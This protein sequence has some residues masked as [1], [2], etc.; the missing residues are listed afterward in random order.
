MS[1]Y[2]RRAYPAVLSRKIKEAILAVEINRQYSKQQILE[3]YLNQIYYGNLAYGI[4]A[5]A[6]TYFGK[7]AQDP[8]LAEASMLAGLPQS[9]AIRPYTNPEGAKNRQTVRAAADGR[10]Q[11]YLPEEA[12]PPCPPTYS[13]SLRALPSSPPFC[14]LRAPRTGKDCPA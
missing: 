7:S 11:L 3:I 13:S 9:P 12:N 4:E 5:A 2:S 14:Q 6:Q 10:S 8:S 1:C